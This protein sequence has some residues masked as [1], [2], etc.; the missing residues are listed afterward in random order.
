M[1]ATT[2]AWREEFKVDAVMLEEEFDPEVF[3]KLGRVYGV[4]KEGRPVTYNLYGV[5]K[6]MGAVFGDVQKFLRCVLCCN[7]P[8]S[9]H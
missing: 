8:A 1:L 7:I 3:G 2:L 6:D 9:V 5:V 4:D